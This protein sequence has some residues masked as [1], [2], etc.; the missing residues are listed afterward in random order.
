MLHI[1][2]TD[3]NVNALLGREPKKKEKNKIKSIQK[4]YIWNIEADKLQCVSEP[5]YT[6][7]KTGAE[8]NS[9]EFKIPKGTNGVIKKQ[10][11]LCMG[12]H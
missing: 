1:E 8:A 3:E 5:I 12:W 7:D 9:C 10:V 6:A 11:L 2:F 4:Y